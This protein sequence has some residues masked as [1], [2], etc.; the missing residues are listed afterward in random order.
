MG[1]VKIPILVVLVKGH[2]KS[3]TS[4]KIRSSSTK[5]RNNWSNSDKLI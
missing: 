5:N 2:N 1:L 3:N 4:N